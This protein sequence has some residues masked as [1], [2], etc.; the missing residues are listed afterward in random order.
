VIRACP[1]TPRRVEWQKERKLRDILVA[2]LRDKLKDAKVET[3]KELKE[4]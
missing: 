4:W 3:F 1:Q 2:L